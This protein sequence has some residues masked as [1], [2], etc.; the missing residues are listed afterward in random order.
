MSLNIKA[1]LHTLE[2]FLKTDVVYLTKGGAWL[3]AGKVIR[4]GVAFILSL[5]YARYLFKSTYGDYRYIFSLIG[6]A[7]IFT[8]PDIGSVIIRGVAR[9]FSGTFRRGALIIFL[10]TTAMTALGIGASIFFFYKGNFPIAY[11][12]LAAAF[13]IPL[14]EG[15]GSWRAYYDGTKEFRKKTEYNFVIQILYVVSMA[16]AVGTVYF[17][18][19]P[20]LYAVALL[21]G[22]Y[23]LAQGVPNIFIMRRVLREIPK[24]APV[25][26]DAIRYG[27]HLSLN[28]IPTNIA[29]YLDTVLLYHFLGPTGVAVYSFA[30]AIPEQLKAFF[31]T[32]AAAGLPK[33]SEKTSEEELRAVRKSLPRKIIKSSLFTGI[34][35][36][37]YIAIAP[38]IYPLFFPRYLESIPFSQIF[39]LSLVTFPFAFLGTALVAEGNIK[40]VFG[41]I[42]LVIKRKK[43]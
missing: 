15:I 41:R 2:R 30:I 42:F 23:L 32:V 11:G 7:S 25:E 39:A 9:G 1:T 26:P 24:A 40:K 38:I 16:F 19:I 31:G 14:M 37:A 20:D 8:F 33:I 28:N 36:F 5:L 3:S 21:V 12:L 18:K 43:I 13:L 35:V 27:F 29:T 10:G 34:L 17:F 6:L 4:V 22:T